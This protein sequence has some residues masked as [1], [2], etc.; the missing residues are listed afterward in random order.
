LIP[1]R[2]CPSAFHRTGD[3]AALCE[4][5]SVVLTER[6]RAAAD[7]VVEEKLI[8]EDLRGLGHDL[9]S[10]DDDGDGGTWCADWTR[11]RAGAALVVR[12]RYG[13]DPDWDSECG[14]DVNFG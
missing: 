14:V 1:E 10:F 12:T 11:P 5:L 6:L 4:E 2:F 13:L 7:R 8:I 3:T 9:W